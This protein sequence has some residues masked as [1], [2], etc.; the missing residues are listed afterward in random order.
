MPSQ[1]SAGE[2]FES[3]VREIL[4]RVAADLGMLI[5]HPVKIQSTAV[6]RWTSKPS[7]ARRVHIAFKLGFDVRGEM[8]YGALLVPLPDAITLASFLLLV[9]DEGVK[10]KRLLNDL[11][12]PTKDAMLE[13]SNFVG[14]ATDGA[15]RV[16]FPQGLSVRS[17]GCQ[18]L[19]ADQ[20]PAFPYKQGD[21]LIVGR[22]KARIGEF[23]Q[24]EMLLVLP[25]LTAESAP[26]T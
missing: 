17:L 22:A 12:Q 8:R 2:P 25:V 26:A 11:D 21:E 6:Q 13:I 5:D 19:R 24:F 15:L 10:G 7:G 16:R 9:P 4:A 20:P 23:P 14:G 3:Q 1:A 18:G